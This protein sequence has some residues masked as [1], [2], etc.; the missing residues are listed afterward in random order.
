MDMKVQLKLQVW[1][2]HLEPILQELLFATLVTFSV[3]S[4]IAHIQRKMPSVRIAI[5]ISIGVREGSIALYVKLIFAKPVDKEE[6]NHKLN[7]LH[8]L[9]N[10]SHKECLKDK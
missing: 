7:T 6:L 1:F 2:M 8:Q 9:D 4:I 10:N 5:T 3:F